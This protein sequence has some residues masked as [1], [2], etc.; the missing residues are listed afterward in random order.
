LY[1]FRRARRQPRQHGHPG[2]SAWRPQA[3]QIGSAGRLD[4]HS[5]AEFCCNQIVRNLDDFYA[6]FDVAAT[7]ELWLEPAARVRIW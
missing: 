1:F 5:P 7:G 6:A 4:R 2:E 3:D